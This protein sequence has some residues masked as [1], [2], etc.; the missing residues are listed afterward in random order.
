MI[1]EST[2]QALIA[3]TCSDIFYPDPEN[4]KKQCFRTT[5][6]TKFQQAFANLSAGVSTFTLPPA[7]GYQH[8]V[9]QFQLPDLTG[10][11]TGLAVPRGWGY[12]LINRMS[13]RIGG[14]SQY[15]LSGQQVLNDALRQCPNGSARD[16]LFALGGQQRIGAELA[17]AGNYAYVWLA[18]PWS[19][20]TAEGMPTPLPSDLLT[21]QVQVQ[22]ELNPLSAIFSQNGVGPSPIPTALASATFTAQQVALHNQGDA[23]ARRVD[24][25][26]HSLSYPVSFTQQEVVIPLAS[27]T[28]VQSVAL[29]GFR[30]GE[31][32]ALE[33]TLTKDSDATGTG[34]ATAKNPN[35]TYLPSS[36]TLTYAGEI[37]A[38]YTAT[39]H[40]LWNLI[41]GKQSSKW[42]G[43][44]LTYGGGAYTG[45]ADTYYWV[46]LPFAQPFSV[47]ETGSRMLVSGKEITNGI[48]NL[49][50]ATPDASADYKLRVSYVYNAVVVF[51]SGTADFA[52]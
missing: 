10:V 40:Q 49:Q 45:T 22:V 32:R 50:I 37:F 14:S 15:F 28:A 7:N 26:T 51:G 25:T 17:G 47:S 34:A 5:Q 11:N 4:S 48:V 18:V 43:S 31:V 19:K 20:P 16:D 23:L 44:T 9:C 52:F 3:G 27:T 1:A 24:M 42:A 6:N 2:Q 12:A 38:Q 29:S 39:S 8:I 30:S 41:N 13:Y 33:I 35:R 36:L 21:Q 46:E